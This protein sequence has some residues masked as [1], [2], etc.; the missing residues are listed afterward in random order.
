MPLARL[1]HNRAAR[2]HTEPTPEGLLRVE[3]ADVPD[4]AQQRELQGL[5]RRLLATAG[6]DQQ[7]AQEPLK[8]ELVKHA[9]G[10]FVAAG[11]VFRE[12]G[13]VLRRLSVRGHC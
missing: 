10:A 1:V 7:V 5:A 2:Q 12:R 13:D 4:D 6:H 8:V 11:H 9:I 3:L